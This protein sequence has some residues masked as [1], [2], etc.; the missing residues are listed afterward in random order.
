MNTA[1]TLR[2]LIEAQDPQNDPLIADEEG[3]E[4][5]DEGDAYEPPEWKEGYE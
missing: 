3:V 1:R 4:Y 2:R 5:P